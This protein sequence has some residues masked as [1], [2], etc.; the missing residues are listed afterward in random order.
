MSDYEDGPVTIIPHRGGRPQM[1]VEEKIEAAKVREEK[2]KAGLQKICGSP[3]R[4]KP[5]EICQ[6]H[7]VQ[8]RSRCRLHGGKTPQGLDSP[9]TSVGI[10]SKTLPA[11]LLKRYMDRLNDP[12]LLSLKGD[13][14][15]TDVHLEDIANTLMASGTTWKQLKDELDKLNDALT[16]SD[17]DGAQSSFEACYRIVSDGAVEAN[18]F[19]DL[20]EGQK[21][22][23][24]LVDT[25]R[26]LITEEAN[27]VQL[28]QLIQ[29]QRVILA[30]IH[31]Y[32]VDEATRYAVSEE[33]RRLFG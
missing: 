6:N 28:D 31:K 24:M 33:F 20:M 26:K 2:R 14:A 22:K 18:R 15:L 13:V 3:K 10:Y 30:I 1:T 23:R 5:G 17:Q 12:E 19:R 29:M 25:E 11:N 8:G 32:I 9:N 7:P 4:G 21:H 16:S 27:S